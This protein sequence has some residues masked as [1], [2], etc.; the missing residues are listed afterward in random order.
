MPN[1][2]TDPVPEIT[3]AYPYFVNGYGFLYIFDREYGDRK[4]QHMSQIFVP[5]RIERTP[6][7]IYDHFKE[8][9]GTTGINPITSLRRSK[10][11]SENKIVEIAKEYANRD[12]KPE[13]P[14]PEPEKDPETKKEPEM[15]QPN[16]FEMEDKPNHNW[17]RD[18]KRYVKSLIK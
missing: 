11:R 12:K 9:E 16:L 6:Q 5:K 3:G 18:A 2:W 4:F 1:Y 14:K 13:E 15:Y 8:M 7:E 17:Y 10:G